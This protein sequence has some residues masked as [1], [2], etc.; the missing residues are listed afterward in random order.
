[1]K[2]S[3]FCYV[4]ILRPLYKRKSNSSLFIMI[5]NYRIKLRYGYLYFHGNGNATTKMENDE[6]FM[7]CGLITSKKK[8]NAR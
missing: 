8:E 4:K 1:M 3:T 2:M 7:Y 5:P 6:S